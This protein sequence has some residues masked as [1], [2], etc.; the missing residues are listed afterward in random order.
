MKQGSSKPAASLQEMGVAAKALKAPEKNVM[1]GTIPAARRRAGPAV[2]P[3][4]P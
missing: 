1:A 3:P 4:G 2:I